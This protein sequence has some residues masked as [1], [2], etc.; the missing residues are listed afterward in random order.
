M[1][2]RMAH[3]ALVKQV[4]LGKGEERFKVK[5]VTARFFMEKMLPETAL[6]LRR[7]EAGGTTT[8]ELP[9]EAF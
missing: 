2:A 9:A 6:R 5:L 1:W 4:A 8:M 3:V 7:I